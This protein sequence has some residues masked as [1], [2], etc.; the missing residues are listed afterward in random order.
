MKK[1]I[2][3][4]VGLLLILTL[5]FSCKIRKEA[6]VNSTSPLSGENF[7]KTAV[8]NNIKAKEAAFNTLSIRAKANLDIDGKDENVTMNIRIERDKAIWISVTAI[9]GLEI[10]R[11]LV[12]P[13]SVKII[14]RLDNTYLKKPFSYIYEFTNKQLNFN[15]LQTLFAGNSMPE[16][17]NDKSTI[18]MQ[19]KSS[20]IDGTIGSLMYAL[21]FNENLKLIQTSL[22][23]EAAKQSLTAAY[24][25]FTTISRQVI[26][27][28]VTIKSSAP[29]KNIGIDLKYNRITVNLSVDLPFNVPQRFKVI[30]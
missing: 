29:G 3:N 12:T 21:T 23:D 5:F 10:A 26:P 7:S 27:Q 11:A 8:F 25:D 6:S 14:N 28:S 9:A 2:V 16:L 17:L 15:T 19:G 30:N 24:E 13:D 1:D 20:V 22:K 4:R 18:T